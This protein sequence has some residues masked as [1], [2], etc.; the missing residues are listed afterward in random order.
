MIVINEICWM[1]TAVS[2]NNE[3]L[4]LYNSGG[5]SV[6]LSGWSLIAK[7]GKPKI[8]LE[9][10]I[11]PQGFFLLERTSDESVPEKKADLIYT[12]ALS[13]KGEHLQLLDKD[14]K[15]IDEVNCQD[16]WWQG[17]NKS[18]QTMERVND[19]LSGH[20]SLNWQTSQGGGG[21]PKSQNSLVPKIKTPETANLLA[22]PSSVSLTA[23]VE[24]KTEE[25][26]AFTEP[27]LSWGFS[28]I[29]LLAL[30]AALVFSLSILFLKNRLLKKQTV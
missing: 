2:A 13:N 3:W 17:D 19:S 10:E 1:G 20:D 6:N 30:A 14:G 9:K 23:S 26:T 22:S 4:E 5:E 28:P 27:Q 12:S 24:E 15:V 25:K 7:D 18:K 8:I 29:F 16:G 21:T 11:K